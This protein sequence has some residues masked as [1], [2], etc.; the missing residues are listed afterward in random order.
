MGLWTL[1]RRGLPSLRHAIKSTAVATAEYIDYGSGATLDN[2]SPFSA[3]ALVRVDVFAAFTPIFCKGAGGA[4]GGW[5]LEGSD[6]VGNIRARADRATADIAYL[7]NDTPLAPTGSWNWVCMTLDRSAGAGAIVRFYTARYGRLPVERTQAAPTDGSGS[8]INDSSE[9]LRSFNFSGGTTHI[10][11][12]KAY[13]GIVSGVAYTAG[14]FG[15]WIK[16]LGPLRSGQVLQVYPGRS[17]TGVQ[18]DESAGANHGTLNGC[19]VAVGPSPRRWRLSG[20]GRP[21]STAKPW[22]YYAQMRAA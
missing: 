16:T 15:S 9:T 3:L 1:S 8:F 7:T 18:V 10:Q 14:E 13:A 6:T 19:T 17:G 11:A 5:V 22:H 2:L 4:V 21:A 20:W 12:A